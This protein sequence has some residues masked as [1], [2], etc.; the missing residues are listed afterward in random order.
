MAPPWGQTLFSFGSLPS[1]P[2]H[3]LVSLPQ[4]WPEVPG[5]AWVQSSLL[6]SAPMGPPLAPLLPS[7]AQLV[8]DFPSIS[9]QGVSALGGAWIQTL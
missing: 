3:T 1:S 6:L 5:E 4:G 2:D 9:I 7:P 8:W